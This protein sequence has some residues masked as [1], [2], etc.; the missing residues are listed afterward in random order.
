[1]SNVSRYEPRQE[2]RASGGSH[3][4]VRSRC[5]RHCSCV[6]RDRSPSLDLATAAAVRSVIIISST[7]HVARRVTGTTLSAQAREW[8]A[9]RAR[10]RARASRRATSAAHSGEGTV[11][12]S[13]RMQRTRAPTT[14]LRSGRGLKAWWKQGRCV[15]RASGRLRNLSVSD[16]KFSR[17][18]VSPVTSSVR[19]KAVAQ[20]L[21][22][23]GFGGPRNLS[24]TGLSFLLQ[25]C[26]FA[27][28]GGVSQ[29]Y[30]RECDSALLKQAR[31][32]ATGPPQGHVSALHEAFCSFDAACIAN[33]GRAERVRA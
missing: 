1:M 2:K 27:S 7:S 3:P 31:S 8:S 24:V 17:S 12:A 13:R 26:F 28:S 30:G 21:R 25:L 18:E 19:E 14:F 10:R 9:A 22:E 23:S 6:P 4:L 33:D 11:G 15:R 20:V 16:N 29:D 32:A 5:T